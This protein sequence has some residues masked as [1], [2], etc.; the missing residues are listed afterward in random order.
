M[1][2]TPAAGRSRT[3]GRVDYEQVG[4]IP[5]RT[6][7]KAADAPFQKAP[8]ARADWEFAGSGVSSARSE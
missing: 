5:A 1:A 8:K 4:A 6:Q 3:A 2:G 7:T